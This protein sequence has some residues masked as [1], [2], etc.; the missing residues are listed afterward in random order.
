MELLS[1]VP[2]SCAF[3]KFI[4][5]GITRPKWKDV[6]HIIDAILNEKSN[7]N[8]KWIA[9]IPQYQIYLHNC[10]NIMILLL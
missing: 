9:K 7:E 1:T 3:S 5:I 8:R 2:G 6:A 10:T 4:S